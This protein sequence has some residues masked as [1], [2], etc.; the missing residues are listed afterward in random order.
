MILA[1]KT[2]IAIAGLLAS[3]ATAAPAPHAIGGDEH[4]STLA[5]RGW[6]DWWNPAPQQT[7]LCYLPNYGAVGKPWESS[8]KPAAYCGN[9]PRNDG[10]WSSIVS[11][12]CGWT[13]RVER[14]GTSIFAC[15][16][17]IGTRPCDC[18]MRYSSALSRQR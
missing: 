12:S 15:S 14:V 4:M 18:D 10:A 1:P 7:S 6:F 3:S 17:F 9:K 8:S 11:G 5:A 16:R 13:S 2:V